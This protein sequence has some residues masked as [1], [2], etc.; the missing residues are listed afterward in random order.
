M[1]PHL[2]RWQD[3]W[4]GRDVTMVYVAEGAKVTPE[5]LLE[6]MRQDGVHGVRLAHDGGGGTSN[7]YGVRAFPTAYVIGRDGTVVWE[8]IPHY[9]PR[10]VEAAVEQAL[11]GPR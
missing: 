4:R 2:V 3:A 5:R 9:D 7:A 10:R 11:A 6:V 1:Q 8:G